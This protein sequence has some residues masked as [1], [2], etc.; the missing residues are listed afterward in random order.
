MKIVIAT[1]RSGSSSFVKYLSKIYPDESIAKYLIHRITDDY[2]DVVKKYPDVFLLDRKDKIAHT[3]SLVF[4][5]IKYGD[6]FKFYHQKEYYDLKGVKKSFLETVKKNFEY[7]SSDLKILSSMYN[8]DIIF[9]ED[10]FKD[11][12]K[13][14]ELNIYNKRFYNKFLDPKHKSR[15]FIKPK[16]SIL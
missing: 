8:K 5:K 4:R 9:Y 1:A 6:D 14:K 11:S 7:Q 12:K 16:K 3:E 2:R 15:L 10:L 13:V